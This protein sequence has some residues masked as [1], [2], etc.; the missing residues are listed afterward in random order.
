MMKTLD[1]IFSNMETNAPEL[2]TRKQ[3][4]KLT[5]GIISEKY[6]ANLDW[7]RKGIEP[8]YQSFN[9]IVYPRAAVIDFLKRHTDNETV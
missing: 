1:E 2:M 6:L 8:R 7:Q 3:I 9:K 4:T 5:G